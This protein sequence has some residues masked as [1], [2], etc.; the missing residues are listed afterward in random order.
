MPTMRSVCLS[1]LLAWGLAG[2]VLAAA[3]PQPSQTDVNAAR[4]HLRNGDE[5]VRIAAAQALAAQ[6]PT[7]AEAVDALLQALDDPQPDVREAATE[8][9]GAIG[10][11]AKAALP[12]L[13]T[14]LKDEKQGW[15]A[16][17]AGPALAQ[18]AGPEIVPQ[19]TELLGNP[20]P[21]LQSA[22]AN[23]LHTLGPAARGAMP[24]VVAGLAP[25]YSPQSHKAMIW[26]IMA[27][28]PEAKEAVPGLLPILD[29]DS[30][31]M[32]YWAQRA[33]A[34]IGPA[35]KPAVPKLIE[36]LAKGVVSVRRH[37]AIA[38]GAIGPGIGPEGLQALE[39]ALDDPQQPVREDAVIAL[40]KLGDF[41]QPAVPAIQ[42][43][44]DKH[45]IAALVPAARSL[46]QL[47]HDASRT[48]P[49]LI[50]ALDDPNAVADAAQMLGELGP[51]ATAAVPALRQATSS[52]DPE[53]RDAAQE[54]L[55]RITPEPPKSP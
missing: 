5:P 22:A 21:V 49:V 40:G 37:S 19:L 7:A 36:L 8:A 28:G 45:R 47:T 23:G 16:Y 41:A 33:L 25:N 53:L 12:R 30:F 50:E 1:V 38:L 27:I 44:L 35:A 55:R 11:A 43:A 24:T 6:G 18:I 31:H 14:Q 2:G 42:R 17:V 10:P 51:A 13:W 52:A 26:V 48:V 54:A 3:E 20:N 15:L 29:S 46:W 34:A 39:R 32:Q 4:E 9:L